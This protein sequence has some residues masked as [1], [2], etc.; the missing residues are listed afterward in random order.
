M[1][2]NSEQKKIARRAQMKKQ[3]QKPG[4]PKYEQMRAML[5]QAQ[6]AMQMQRKQYDDKVLEVATLRAALQNRDL[7]LA[8][9]VG[10]VGGEVEVVGSLVEEVQ[11]G[12]YA[13]IDI[14]QTDD[15][16]FTISLVEAEVQEYDMMIPADD[17]EDFETPVAPV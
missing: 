10:A 7:V 14:D 11:S 1:G 2:S 15:G 13:G 17:E 9:V 3:S 8:A 5:G 6:T 4:M 16:G 12:V